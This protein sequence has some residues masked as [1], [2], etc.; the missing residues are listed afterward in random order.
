MVSIAVGRTVT[1]PGPSGTQSLSWEVSGTGER[2]EFLVL[3]ARARLDRLDRRLD[4]LP[5]ATAAETERGVVHAKPE[6]PVA[7][8]VDG[9]HLNAV[10]ADLGEALADPA[11]IRVRAWHFNDAGDAPTR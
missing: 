9:E 11:R 3:L 7:V 4:A 1:L 10:L 8:R 5:A 2:E 6:P